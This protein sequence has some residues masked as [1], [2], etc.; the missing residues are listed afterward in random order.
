MC[1]HDMR[2]VYYAVLVN[3]RGNKT[4]PMFGIDPDRTYH[5]TITFHR[6][7]DSRLLVFTCVHDHSARHNSRDG[8]EI[9]SE[10][11]K[12]K[13]LYAPIAFA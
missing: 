5:F 8:A 11:Y 4:D 13:L 7:Y 9:H 1:R 10:I 2:Y 12:Y 3:I 6:F